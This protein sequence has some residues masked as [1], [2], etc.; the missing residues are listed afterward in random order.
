MIESIPEAQGRVSSLSE[1]YA[2]AVALILPDLEQNTQTPQQVETLRSSMAATIG[3]IR[4]F[5]TDL[6]ATDSATLVA[7]VQNAGRLLQVWSWERETRRAVLDFTAGVLETSSVAASLN[8][9]SDRSTVTTREGET[10]Q[11]IAQREL[12]DYAAW[13]RILDANPGLLPGQLQSGT[14]L[15]LPEKR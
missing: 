11:S 13:P 3:G 9:G 14:T 12:G 1:G 10:L 8:A 6:D 4:S 15:I 7:T 2:E 5:R